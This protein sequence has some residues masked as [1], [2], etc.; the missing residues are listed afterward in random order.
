MIHGMFN[1]NHYSSLENMID[2]PNEEQAKKPVAFVTILSVIFGFGCY[3]LSYIITPMNP[4]SSLIGVLPGIWLLRGYIK[5]SLRGMNVIES[6]QDTITRELVSGKQSY[7][8]EYGKQCYGIFLLIFFGITVGMNTLN[9]FHIL[10]REQII[11]LI[12]AVI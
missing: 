2:I 8:Q 12:N 5:R 7:S 1:Y 9:H 6:E 10:T 4:W 11:I 3:E